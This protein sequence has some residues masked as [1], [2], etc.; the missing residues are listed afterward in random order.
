[1]CARDGECLPASSVRFIHVNWTLHGQPAGGA[2]CQS[3]P[4][5][6]IEF[7]SAG[8]TDQLG[9]APVPCAEGKFTVDKLPT[10]YTRV[11]LG[12]DSDVGTSAP[13]DASTGNAT[14]DLPY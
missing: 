3:S 10:W 6:L 4:D 1:V 8:N 14:I 7:Y 5:L 12:R 13:I 11:E 2:I 9:Y